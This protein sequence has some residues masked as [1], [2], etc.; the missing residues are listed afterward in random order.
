M[1]KIGE[2]GT[3]EIFTGGKSGAPLGKYKV[4]VTTV[5]VPTDKGKGGPTFDKKYTDAAKSKLGFEVVAS[6]EAGR[7]DLQLSK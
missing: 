2:D 7:Y 1:G 4:L 3:Y 6:A 5:T